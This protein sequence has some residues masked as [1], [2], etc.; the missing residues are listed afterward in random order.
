MDTQIKGGKYDSIQRR[1]FDVDEIDFIEKIKLTFFD[2]NRWYQ[3][4]GNAT[5]FQVTDQKGQEKFGR[6]AVGDLVK[7]QIPG[8]KSNV[9]GGYDWVEIHEI[10]EMS[11][12]HFSKLSIVLTP[13]SK[14]GSPYNIAHFY[15]SLS[16]NY[17]S[18]I[19]SPT[20]I[21]AEVHGRNE[22]PNYKNLSLRDKARNFL[23]ANGGLFGLGKIHWEIWATNI[24]KLN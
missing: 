18:I 8:P 9:G 15:S 12:G 21:R 19:Y 20:E 10:S 17:F 1:Y 16:K 22:V 6:I 7:I 13:C 5:T 3:L 24:L 14:P 4:F 23:V 2:I 11:K